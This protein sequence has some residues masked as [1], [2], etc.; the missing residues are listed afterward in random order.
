MYCPNTKLPLQE[1][2][3]EGSS[4]RRLGCSSSFVQPASPCWSWAGLRTQ[5]RC[6][7]IPQ[8]TPG[9]CYL[10]AFWDEEHFSP[11]L[12]LQ[13]VPWLVHI[14]S[15]VHPEISTLQSCTWHT[16]VR[17]TKVVFSGTQH[18]SVM[19]C[20]CR[21][22]SNITIVIEGPWRAPGSELGSAQLHLSTLRKFQFLLEIVFKTQSLH[23]L[24]S[25]RALQVLLWLL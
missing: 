23:L 18:P 4:S 3:T 22:L 12:K 13:C 10:G 1:P 16:L 9:P 21:I 8:K 6:A 19:S 20:K 11:C 14:H 25:L 15:H 24:Y 2:T 5:A 7:H 17:H